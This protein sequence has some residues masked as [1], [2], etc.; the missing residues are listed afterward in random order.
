M[1]F[2]EFRDIS[3]GD[4]ESISRLISENIEIA[5][6]N[7]RYAQGVLVFNLNRYNDD[8]RSVPKLRVK[9]VLSVVAESCTKNT[10]YRVKLILDQSSKFDKYYANIKEISF[11]DKEIEENVTDNLRLFRSL[12][13]HLDVSAERVDE[14]AKAM[15]LLVEDAL[16]RSPVIA[17]MIIN[18]ASFDVSQRPAAVP[19]ADENRQGGAVPY[20]SAVVSPPEVAPAKWYAHKDKMS[21]EDFLRAY[22]RPWLRENG[23]GIVTSEI[24]QLDAALGYELTKDAVRKF[25]P[26]DVRV[27]LLKERNETILHGI[28]EGR[29]LPPIDDKKRRAL[30]QAASRRDI[31]LPR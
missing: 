29:I 28:A 27:P 5:M 23:L 24:R 19:V 20:E 18:Y 26:P 22:W 17:S 16:G 15:S 4:I 9:D 1:D 2:S 25:L 21:V 3:T 6:K 10:K 11:E 7:Q 14:T 31:A 30:E 12:L 13:P 8:R